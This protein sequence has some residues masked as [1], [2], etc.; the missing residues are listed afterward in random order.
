VEK[1]TEVSTL[2]MNGSPVASVY[3]SPMAMKSSHVDHIS[4][5]SAG[6]VGRPACSK[7]SAR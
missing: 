4:A 1:K 6:S 3:C 5:T 7:R 2:S